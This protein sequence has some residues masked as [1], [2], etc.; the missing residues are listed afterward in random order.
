MISAAANPSE[1][2]SLQQA[3][4]VAAARAQ[5][6]SATSSASSTPPGA[7]SATQS[8]SSTQSDTNKAS[9][10]GSSA[11]TGK[12]PT[13]DPLSK[14]Q[15]AEVDQLV[16][17]DK[18]TRAH[19]QAHLAAA[20]ALATSGANYKMTTG[21]DGKQYANGGD[22]SVDVSPGRTP[23]ET[24]RKARIIQAAAL[25]PSQPS[26]QD[27]AVAAQARAM[28]AQAQAEISARGSK[29]QQVAGAYQPS[30]QI[31]QSLFSASA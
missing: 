16:K 30:D 6:S 7:N 8:T 23:E 29:G 21:P 20:G 9:A 10:N 28:E 19:E 25:A 17:I 27:I 15:Q 18:E 4:T 26:G 13:G 1:M 12:T 24:I 14:S 31:S 5:Q 22:V 11:T 2:T 3:S